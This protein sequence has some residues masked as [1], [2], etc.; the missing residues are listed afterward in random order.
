MDLRVDAYREQ[1]SDQGSSQTEEMSS[2]ARHVHALLDRTEYRRCESGEDFENIYRLRYNSYRMNDLVPENASRM[3]HDHF[4]ELPNCH[5]FGIY[6]DDRLVSTLRLHDVS[7][8]TPLSPAFSVYSDLL[9]PRVA[10]GEVFIDPSRFAVDV[11]WSRLYPPIPYITLRLAGMACFHFNAPY[12]IS[13]IR[14]DH[15]AFYKRIYQARPIGDAR[16]YGG[17]INCFA[18]L[19]QA[20]VLAIKNETYARFPFFKSTPMEQRM[21]FGKPPKG[22]LAP[23]TILPTAKYYREAA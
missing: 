13:M 5:T 8:A 11:E 12:C 22:E 3:V 7:T 15:A 20:D 9:A 6:V 21:M 2:F 16:P 17:V 23:L 4:D 10:A 14:E 19:Y 18:L 1:S